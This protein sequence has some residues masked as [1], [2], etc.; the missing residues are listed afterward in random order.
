MLAP[1]GT[2]KMLVREIM[3]PNPIVVS[4]D[5][6]AS[7]VFDLMEKHG[8][9]HVPTVRNGAVVGLAT[10]RMIRDAQPSILTLRDPAARRKALGA[11]RV[12]DVTVRNP[13]TIAPD[14]SV[15]E[16]IRAMHGV[17]GGSLPVIDRGRIVGILTAGDLLTLLERVLDD[18]A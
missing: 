4:D 9:R 8:I 5:A 11:I 3:T 18:R 2:R 12:A 1:M 15:Q 6:H 7:D 17:R 16:A 13:I 10:E 14:A